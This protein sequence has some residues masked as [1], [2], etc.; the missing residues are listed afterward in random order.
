[1]GK[2]LACGEYGT[3]EEKNISG[4]AERAKN[5]GLRT[6]SSIVPNKAAKTI[7]ELKASPIKRIATG[8]S[9]FDRVIGGGIVDGE[10]ILFAGA[11][12]AGKS[13]LSLSISNCL[14]SKGMKILYSSGEESDSQIA[15]RAKRMR[16]DNDNIRITNETNLETLIG[17]IESE[18]P[19]VLIVDSLQTIASTEI[20]GSIGSISQSREAAHSLTRIAKRDSIIMILIN[21]IIKSGEFAGSEA[22]QHIVD[23][24]IILESDNDT[25]FK[26]LRANKNR[27]GDT[28]EAG[29]FQHTE[30]GL[31]EVSDPSGILIDAAEINERVIGASCSFISEGIRQLP[32]E[33]QALV[34]KSTLPNPR[35]QFSGINFNRGQIVCAILDKYC[36]VRLYEHDVFISTIS[37]VKVNDPQSD[38]SIAASLLSSAKD[39]HLVE[40]TLFVGEITLTGQVRGNFMIDSKIREAE[41]LNFDRIV[42]SKTSLKAIKQKHTVPVEAISSVKELTKFLR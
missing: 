39:K 2:C 16:V 31:T 13:S 18:K 40:R 19:D 24:S 20:P 27:F 8:I 23:C 28:S 29:I 34:N 12:G 25:P 10:V 6:S 14:A 21:Q 32:V 38:L 41:R 36:G 26:V 3:L 4:G 22:V 33:I 30:L 37:G 1:M 42:I 7:S 9:E 11:P 17:H 35:K 5:A 15:L